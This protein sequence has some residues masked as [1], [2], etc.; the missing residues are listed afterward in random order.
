[1]T[2]APLV[3]VVI[4]HLNTPDLLH[5]CLASVAGQ[6]LR[7]GS[8]EIIVVDN[9]STVPFDAVR[10]AFPTVRFLDEPLAGPGLARNRGAAAA[11]ASILAFID[12]DCRAAPGWLQ[13]AHD[14][15]AADPARGLF[16]GDIRIDAADPAHLTGMEAFE[17]V[18]G[19]RQR[20]YIT[21]L[22]FSVTANLAMAAPVLAAV[23]P[24]GGIDI[25]EDKD[26]GQRA[27]AMGYPTRFEPAMQV[28]HPARPDLPSMQRKWVRLIDHDR[29]AHVAG[30]APEWRWRL[31]AAAL[32]ASVPVEAMKLLATPRLSGL[33]TRLRGI[34]ALARIRWF[35]CREMLRVAGRP[36]STSAVAWNRNP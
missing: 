33:A 18:F 26:W 24:F 12:A 29:R 6:S 20:W 5:K 13:A 9:G 4:P 8:F 3:S 1:M 17:T 2:A 31:R 23:G 35:R 10:D 36:A 19:F 11:R 30:G 21:A 32:V 28:W 34:D 16:G 27:F 7:G 15:V 25:A 22:H 14:A